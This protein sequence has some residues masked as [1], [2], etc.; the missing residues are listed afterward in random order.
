MDPI[1]KL[2]PFKILKEKNHL[3]IIH[4]NKVSPSTL[5]IFI[6]KNNNFYIKYKNSYIK[7]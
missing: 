5:L 2:H 1:I 4:T 7:K 3:A 6:F